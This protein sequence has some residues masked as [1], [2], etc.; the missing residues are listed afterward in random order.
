MAARDQ[1]GFTLLEMLVALVVF[2]LL[3]GLV[4]QGV[5][6]MRAGWQAAQAR[7]QAVTAVA[8]AQTLVQRLVTEARPF[9]AMVGERG[10]L[11]LVVD[12]P[13]GSG[14]AAAVEIR[15]VDGALVAVRA[16]VDPA[17][18]DPYAALACGHVTVLVPGI[19]TGGFAYLGG[20]P[21][22]WQEGWSDAGAA[23]RLVRLRL[24]FHHDD[25]R[26]WP[27]LYAHPMPVP[28]GI[29]LDLIPVAG[30]MP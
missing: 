29:P 26:Q 20:T 22:A 17:A 21:P 28:V 9:P 18:A 27:D 23:P 5:R 6:M 19:A 11:R 10:R 25:S 1:S 4:A 16:P 8:A 24:F 30:A 12:L 14:Q 7:V 2:G 3:M 13:P 15:V